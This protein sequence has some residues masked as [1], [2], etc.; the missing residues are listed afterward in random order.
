MGA[1]RGLGVPEVDVRLDR[2]TKV[3]GDVAAVDDLSL[4]ITTNE[5]FSLLGPSGC[6]KTTTLRMIGGFE[7]PTYGTVYLGGQDVTDLPPYERDVNTVFQSYAL[8]P[9]LDVFENVAFGLRRKKVE[10]GEIERRVG[11]ALALV[12]LAGFERRR[13]RQMSGGQQQRVAL[14][15]ALVN[16]PKVL[17][18][19]EPLGALDL[20]LRK[21]MQLE[22]KTIQQEVGITFIYVTHDQ[23]EAMTMSN[24][25]AVMRHGRIEQLG[26]PEDVYEH[27]ATEFVA[28][29]LGASNLLDGEIA[30]LNGAARVRLSS[31]ETV[32]AG[33]PSI[34][35]N[36]GSSVKVGVR[37]EK[38]SIVPEADGDVSGRNHVVGTV[39]MATYIG[40]NYQYKVDGPGGRELTVF[41][42][43][44]GATGSQPTVGQR[45]R[46]EWL[47]EH[48]FVVEP[49]EEPLEEEGQ[50]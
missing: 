19:D 39:R 3:F 49:A 5:F 32:L 7:D 27:P 4:D 29:F 1:G 36:V 6:G 48:T 41:V 43:N 42:Q 23:E 17:L 12:D 2:V 50:A 44:Q 45:V 21:Q 14:A 22:L 35:A 28:G 20:K 11:E 25:L 24:R 10:K 8:F 9:H 47:P 46:L 16:R 13:P 15:R 31:G 26:A 34:G 33:D 18:L 38:I 40:V 37:P 30:S